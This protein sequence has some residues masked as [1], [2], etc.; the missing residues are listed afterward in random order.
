MHGV[1]LLLALH[2]IQCC[3]HY[4]SR[5]HAYMLPIS[6]VTSSVPLAH[7]PLHTSYRVKEEILFQL[8]ERGRIATAG[9]I[10]CQWDLWCAMFFFW[11]CS[12]VTAALRAND[13]SFELPL[14]SLLLVLC[15]QFASPSPLL[16]LLSQLV[17]LRTICPLAVSPVPY[18]LP[19]YFPR[20]LQPPR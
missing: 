11:H 17:S 18:R 19:G 16:C 4:L 14:V 1:P 7:P 3:E 8:E 5:V 6:L 13:C 9:T 2:R 10:G 20:C 12:S 15:W